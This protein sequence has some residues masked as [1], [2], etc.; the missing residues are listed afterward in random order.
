MGLMLLF[1]DELDEDL[2]IDVAGSGRS[3][4]KYGDMD[5]QAQTM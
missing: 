2:T 4:W 3:T 5:I 1:C